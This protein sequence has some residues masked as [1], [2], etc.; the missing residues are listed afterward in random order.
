MRL[1]RKPIPHGVIGVVEELAGGIIRRRQAVERIVGVID[2]DVHLPGSTGDLHH[3]F[4]APGH[5][6]MVGHVT[7][8]LHIVIVGAEA[9]VAL[10]KRKDDL[11]VR[12]A[13]TV[14][15]G[16]CVAVTCTRMGEDVNRQPFL[17]H[18][19][20]VDDADACRQRDGHQY[21]SAERRSPPYFEVFS[22]LKELIHLTMTPFAI[23]DSASKA[24]VSPIAF[25]R[26]FRVFARINSS[27]WTIAWH[28]Q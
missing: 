27:R 16:L 18:A 22:C 2:G 1:L 15:A 12:V 7:P 6:A 25:L 17:R 28:L 10:W 26:I 8:E 14:E 5:G 4:Q 24:R 21:A 19:V 9:V 23:Q 13:R 3:R 11:P 20:R